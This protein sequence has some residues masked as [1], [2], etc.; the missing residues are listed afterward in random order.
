MSLTNH[1][2]NNIAQKINNLVLKAPQPNE[3]KFFNEPAPVEL[4]HT[5]L[6]E[7]MIYIKDAHVSEGVITESENIESKSKK[8]KK[9]TF[10]E[11][12]IKDYSEPPKIG[13]QPGSYPTSDLLESYLKSCERHKCKSI[14]KLLQQLKALQDLDCSN[15]E[16]VN[17]LNLKNE[18]IDSKQIETLEEIFK[19]LS[20]KTIDLEHT[21]LE[22]ESCASTL[23]EILA[24]YDTVERLIIS[25][26]KTIIN[27]IG[28]QELSKFIRKGTCLEYL[29][30]RGH[31]FSELIYFTYFARSIKLTTTLRV[32]HLEQSN[33]SGRYLLMLAAALKDNEQIRELYLA[34]NKIQATDGNSIANIIKENNFLEVLDLR[35]NNIL[36]T[37]LSHICSGL[38]EQAN[39]HKGLKALVLMNNN[40]TANGISYL[41]KALIHNRSLNTLN[42]AHN[43]LTN[44][45][46]YELKEALIVNKQ[47]T[48]LFLNKTKLSDEGVIALAEY[49]AETISLNRLDLRDND[50]RLG[51]LMALVSSLK[52]NNTLSRLDV[53][54]EPRKEHNFF[55]ITFQLK[56][57][58]ETS[59]RLLQDLNEYCLR[60]QR[61]QARKEAERAELAR[62]QAEERRL[63][64]I[65]NEKQLL[66]LVKEI[67][68]QVN[69]NIEVSKESMDDMLDQIITNTSKGN[70]EHTEKKNN[71]EI[72]KH[73]DENLS[74]ENQFADIDQ[75]N[76]SHFGKLSESFQLIEEVEE[77]SSETDPDMVIFKSGT[78]STS[79]ISSTEDTL[80]DE[81]IRLDVLSVTN[82]LI[83]KVVWNAK[84]LEP[85]K[86]QFL[87]QNS[88]NLLFEPVKAT[89]P[90]YLID[91]SDFQDQRRLENFNDSNDL[92]VSIE[93]DN[94][95]IFEDKPLNRPIITFT[96]EDNDINVKP[97]NDS[98]ILDEDE[99]CNDSDI[100]VLGVVS[101]FISKMV[102]LSPDSNDKTKD[103]SN[104]AR[105]CSGKLDTINE[106]DLKNPENDQTT[107]NI[108]ANGIISNYDFVNDDQN[109]VNNS[110][111]LS[112]TTES[113]LIIKTKST[114]LKATSH[115]QASSSDTS[116]ILS[117]SPFN[118]FS[119]K[120]Y[121]L[122]TALSP[123]YDSLKKTSSF[124]SSTSSP[125]NNR[126]KLI[127]LVESEILS[128]EKLENNSE[129]V[130]NTSENP[131]AN[132]RPF[133]ASK[134]TNSQMSEELSNEIGFEWD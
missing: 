127:N 10:P 2:I 47:I 111:S 118:Q 86:I 62:Q 32:V 33:I 73:G 19:R 67:N 121:N 79:E 34:D 101:K 72:F 4:S 48:S 6:T 125:T 114:P 57:S 21:A 74:N 92:S 84:R 78:E 9:V 76:N 110:I 35:N 58:L 132:N 77:E 66:E 16:K 13:W 37:G 39:V 49:I 40:I 41:S 27:L 120:F 65:E 29:D 87:H 59:R 17:Y 24:Y 97:F 94:S 64:Q 81:Q 85:E 63:L 8:K 107:E 105:L 42:I 75:Y 100:E 104:D 129:P 23:F 68:T 56:D 126:H 3:I 117:T 82:S 134:M 99:S 128:D 46:I 90:K 11:N 95:Q 98:S 131:D 5:S 70:N 60:N 109:T 53:D 45:A 55:H 36:D 28:W 88:T 115:E 122:D 50:I 14:G 130:K 69:Q 30:V 89:S 102:T 93:P 51:G 61:T 113:D 91:S 52:F 71:S 44:E 22:D 54:R 15:G 83:E 133:F 1:A 25:N 96:N 106:Q 108:G 119:P 26:S 124:S 18:R 20:F 43:S 112:S 12:V 31:T 38:S 123:P 80:T 103:E 7:S 116:L